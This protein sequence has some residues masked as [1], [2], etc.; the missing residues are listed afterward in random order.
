MHNLPFHLVHEV[1]RNLDLRSQRCLFLSSIRL[2]RKC[3]LYIPANPAWHF[4]DWG[5]DLLACCSEVH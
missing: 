2:Y 3:Q 5:L 4:L 1:S